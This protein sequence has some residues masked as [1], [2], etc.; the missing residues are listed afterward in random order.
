MRNQLA[1]Q[2]RS[3]QV[4]K[5]IAAGLIDRI[6]NQPRLAIPL[7]HVFADI[8]AEIAPAQHLGHPPPDGAPVGP[9]LAQKWP[10]S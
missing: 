5:P 10:H 6:E 3:E 4:V 2:P 8:M 7:R 1:A 9:R